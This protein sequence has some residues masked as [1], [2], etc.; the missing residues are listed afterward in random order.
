MLQTEI[1]G[2]GQKK[3]KMIIEELGDLWEEKI[4]RYAD[5]KKIIKDDKIIENIVNLMKGKFTDNKKN[6]EIYDYL[7]SIHEF[8]MNELEKITDYYV[9]KY[10]T[11]TKEKIKQNIYKLRKLGYNFN[12]VDNIALKIP[13]DKDS[14]IRIKAA[15]EYILENNEKKGNT[16]IEK[17]KLICDITKLLQN[18]NNTNISNQ[19][20]NKIIADEKLM[21]MYNED[22]HERIMNYELE[23]HVLD[24]HIINENK[25]KVAIAVKINKDEHIQTTN[26]NTEEIIIA[27]C[28][29]KINSTTVKMLNEITIREDIKMIENEMRITLNIEQVNAI[30][31]ALN[32]RLTIITGGPGRGKSTI[33]NIIVRIFKKYNL[34]NN[35]VILTAYTALATNNLRKKC[36]CA[37]YNL[38]ILTMHKLIS[39]Y[40]YSFNDPQKIQENAPWIRA[41][42]LII[43]D[44]MSL[45]DTNIFSKII[46]IVVRIR[47]R[48]VILGDANQLQS[49][50][51]GKIL[52]DII[53]HKE[54]H[55]IELKNN[56]RQG[57]ES[58]IIKV[59]DS[60]ITNEIPNIS[61]IKG[62]DFEFIPEEK[63][64]EILRIIIKNVIEYE[65]KT[66]SIQILTPQKT[67]I[68]GTTN[69][70]NSLQKIKNKI[71][72]LEN[73]IKNNIIY[74]KNTKI[75]GIERR[76]YK[77][78][79]NDKIMATKNDYG[80]IT[81]NTKLTD[82][83][84]LRYKN[85][86]QH[87]NTM[88]VNGQCGKVVNVDESFIYIKY[89]IEE[90][91]KEDTIVKY[92]HSFDK[93]N[94]NDNSLKYKINI[95][96]IKLAYCL[97]VHKAQGQEYDVVIMPISKSH[98]FMLE[99]RLLYTA[100]SRGK[101]KVILIGS[102]EHFKKAITIEK[103]VRQTNLLNY[104]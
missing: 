1:I 90:E 89:D 82:S 83:T 78:F 102:I 58:G 72:E 34:H 24:T 59:L 48:L 96:D 61:L 3:S 84:K 85:I 8:K 26:I 30:I 53:Q 18:A 16:I 37:M 21:K 28:L 64:E 99:K 9:N 98:E 63:D 20:N 45:V 31:M 93:I 55:Q 49:I 42:P 101:T 17:N 57:E 70:N 74:D 86:N 103:N 51:A 22:I 60:I 46:E 23:K 67:G 40:Y 14:E 25:N 87:D 47:G 73:S 65:Q 62:N 81:D 27:S 15:T 76:E 97:T 95:E 43:I 104:F 33:A 5:L 75:I 36:N 2:V 69:L 91:I 35:N 66:K 4:S 12:A 52:T 10:P 32:N 79:I 50:G 44:E 6:I 92:I 100:I 88:V 29:N 39:K 56:C 41:Y 13:I 80:N 94:P 19:I 71:V 38:E 54:T 68:I 77:I 11:D 7:S